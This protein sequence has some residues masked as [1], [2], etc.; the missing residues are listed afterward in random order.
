[1]PEITGAEKVETNGCMYVR[2]RTRINLSICDL[3]HEYETQTNVEKKPLQC[4]MNM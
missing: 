4:Q 2:V 3:K 1:M